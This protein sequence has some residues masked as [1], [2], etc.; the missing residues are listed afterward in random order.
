VLY[1]VLLAAFQFY[2][3]YGGLT[4]PPVIWGME[5]SEL[6][7]LGLVQVIRIFYGFEANR[8][9]NRI[10]SVYFLVLSIA[11]LLV[12]AH[13]SYMT[14]YVLMIEILLGSIIGFLMVLEILLSVIAIGKFKS[15]N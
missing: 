12:I 8:Q 15:F 9:E 13:Y 14:T 3:W 10:S 11:S 2:K 7:M 6:T 4:Y 5:F 1:I